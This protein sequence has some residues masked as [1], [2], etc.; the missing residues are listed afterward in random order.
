MTGQTSGL[1]C[2]QETKPL[3]SHSNQL[4]QQAAAPGNEHR[5]SVRW[6]SLGKKEQFLRGLIAEGPQPAKCPAVEGI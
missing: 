1:K 3:Y 6:F 4:P 5:P 2:G